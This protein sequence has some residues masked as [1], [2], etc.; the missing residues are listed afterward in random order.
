M[1]C[2]KIIALFSHTEPEAHLVVS[3]NA[4]WGLFS[5]V[6]GLNNIFK[7]LLRLTHFLQMFTMHEAL[8]YGWNIFQI[9]G[10]RIFFVFTLKKRI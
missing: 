10:L 5:L 2:G 3:A 4:K 8:L 6:L 7:E 9:F 1:F